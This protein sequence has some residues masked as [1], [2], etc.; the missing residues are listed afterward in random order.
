MSIKLIKSSFYQEKIVKDKLC[1]FIQKAEQFSFGNYCKKFESLFAKWQNRKYC[2]FVNS[3]SSANIA[4]LQ[5]LINMGKLKKGDNVGFSSL[6]WST[7]V[8]PIIEL[9]LTPVPIDVEIS[10]LNVSL[11]TLKKTLQNKK[12]SVFLITNLL[13]FSDNIDEIKTFCDQS[14]IIL[15]EDNCES[16]GTVYKGKKLGNFGLASTF[17]TYVGHHIST[18]EGGMVC[19]DDKDLY[20]MLHMVR[21]HGWDRNL[22][23][24]LQQEIRNKYNLDN[25]YS[26]YTFYTLGYNLR[27]NEITGFLGCEQ[28]NYIDEI[29]QKREKNFKLFVFH[30][31]NNNDFYS[32]KHEHLDF[33]SNFAIPVICKTKELFY[34][35]IEKFEKAGVEIRPI[36]GGD[37]TQQIFWKNL[38]G[39]NNKNTN[40][41]YIHENGFYFGNSPEYNENEIDLLCSL[42]N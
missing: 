16:M 14:N 6:T 12:L 25:F 39:E 13:G 3:G 33:V 23:A 29:I 9:G 2:V 37:M 11:E 28:M 21:A 30:L 32:I 27:P 22:D 18:I 17:S 20:V 42:L 15:L 36:V 5:A 10:T 31:N 41:K 24:D 40:S 35:Y 34:A 7:D 19:T 8:M 4:L 26:K 1:D 38:Y